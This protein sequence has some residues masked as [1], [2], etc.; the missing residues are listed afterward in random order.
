[1]HI[2]KKIL[3]IGGTCVLVLAATIGGVTA[4]NAADS[5]V[6]AAPEKQLSTMMEKVAEIYELNTGTAID[7]TELEKAFEQAGA[8]MVGNRFETMLDKLVEEGVIT[9]EQ[10]NQWQTWWESRPDKALSEEFETWMESR[11]DIP[12]IPGMPGLRGGI[13]RMKV[14]GRGFFNGDMPCRD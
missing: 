12:D 1:M 11:P 3:I 10:A 2:S 13:Q 9:Q 5:G 14:T 4:A 6:T 7:A 8:D